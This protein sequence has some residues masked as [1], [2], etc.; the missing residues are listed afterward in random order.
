VSVISEKSR[1]AGGKIFDSVTDILS[2]VFFYLSTH[3]EQQTMFHTF[4]RPNIRYSIF[5]HPVYYVRENRLIQGILRGVC[6]SILSCGEITSKQNFSLTGEPSQYLV[7]PV[8]K[9]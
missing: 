8:N 7:T 6:R 4:Y 9:F 5:I 1:L 3:A 2:H